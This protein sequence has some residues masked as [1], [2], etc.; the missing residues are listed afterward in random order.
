MAGVNLATA[1]YQLMPSM[2]G[3]QAAISAQMG[4]AGAAGSKAFNSKFSGGLDGLKGIA[5][6]AAGAAV[7][8]FVKGAI[9]GA[10]DLNETMS[11]SQVIFGK[12]AAGIAQWGKTAST[13]LGLSQG[14]AVAAAS[15]FGNMFTQLGFGQATAAKMS[16]SVVQ[17][18]ADLGSFNNLPTSDVAE[19]ISAAF[20]GE[21]DSLQLLVP[22]I[23]AARVEKQAMAMT[24]KT[25]AKQLTAQEKAAAVLA[26]VHKD[27][28]KAMGDFARTSSGAANQS[29]IVSAQFQDLKNKIGTALLPAVRAILPAFGAFIGFIAAHRSVMIAIGVVIG[30]VLV[31]ALVAATAAAW[32]FTFALLANPITWIVVAIIALIAGI[33]LLIKNWDKVKAKTIAVWKAIKTAVSGAW[34]AIRTAIVSKATAVLTFVKSIPDRIAAFFHALPG[35]LKQIGSDIV[36]GLRDGIAGAWH[37]VTSKVNSL[38]AQIPLAIR[39]FLGIA[40]PSKLM[41]EIGGHVATG[42]ALG[43]DKGAGGVQSSALGLASSVTGPIS[44]NANVS[45]AGRSGLNRNDLDYLA[46]RI[47]TLM[48]ISTNAAMSD[49]LAFAGRTGRMR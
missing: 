2:A 27:G 34:D 21:Y 9:S 16:K 15:D 19:R 17:M 1:Y 14:E 18:S 45:T 48:G 32:S 24:G 41:M 39:K 30:V 5:A 10:S 3:N 46:N 42:L 36:T 25:N 37:W 40:S 31:A 22:N 12:S 44:A 8:G 20:R 4:A 38:I 6:G 29:K 23:N 11:K 47:A 13:N 7:V 26:I 35:R 49:Q 28:S 43:M 33:V